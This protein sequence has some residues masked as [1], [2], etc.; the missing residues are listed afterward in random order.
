MLLGTKKSG[1]CLKNFMEKGNSHKTPTFS[2]ATR[3]QHMCERGSQGCCYRKQSLLFSFNLLLYF[4]ITHLKQLVHIWKTS[5]LNIQ[6]YSKR[7]FNMES[8][9]V[10]LMFP[11]RCI[12]QLLGVY[13]QL[14]KVC[15]LA[16]DALGVP[17][18]FS[19]HIAGSR[20]SVS[21]WRVE[22]ENRLEWL[23]TYS[24]QHESD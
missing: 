13:Y 17:T 6:M 16:G 1:F 10:F 11:W 12:P 9:A 24:A 23:W 8:S 4:F 7:H 19:T 22:G 21:M 3:K 2:A 18:V 5:G 14:E 20:P 15:M